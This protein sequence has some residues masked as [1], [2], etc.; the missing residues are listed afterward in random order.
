MEDRFLL[1]SF[2]GMT[3]HTSPPNPKPYSI[4]TYLYD[5]TGR[6]WQ[7]RSLSSLP[8]RTPK[9]ASI[10]ASEVPAIYRTQALING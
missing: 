3:E 10:P 5:C 4:K 9:W 6:H 1:F 8:R 2:V 7:R